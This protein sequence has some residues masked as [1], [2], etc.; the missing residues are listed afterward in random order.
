MRTKLAERGP[1]GHDAHASANHRGKDRRGSNLVVVSNRLPIRFDEASSSWVTAAGGLVSAM[2]PVLARHDGTWVGWNP[3][4]RPMAPMRSMR[5]RGVALPVDIASRYYA[6]YANSVLWPTLHGM[7]DRV[8]CR[9]SWWESY[10]SA[11]EAFADAV[12]RTARQG[13]TVWVHD[14]HL[15]LVPSLLAQRRPDLVIGL[16]LHTP[17]ADTDAIE[18]LEHCDELLAGMAGAQLIGTQR[19]CDATRLRS[20]L[21]SYGRRHR[22]RVMSAVHAHPISVDVDSIV[23]V[24]NDPAV[25]EHA[26][27]VRAQVGAGRRIVLSVDRLDYTKGILERLAAFEKLLE[28]GV[29]SPD[30]V[31]LVQIAP[32][33]RDELP[34]YRD[35]AAQVRARVALINVR[36]PSHRGPAVGLQCETLPFSD[37]AAFYLAADVAMVT[38]LRDGMN[39]VAKEFVTARAGE[40]AC[41]VL[42]VGAGA[43]DELGSHAVLVDAADPLDLAAG[44]H[45]AL[46]L[47]GPDCIARSTALGRTVAN[48]DVHRWADE[49]LADLGSMSCAARV[50]V[51]A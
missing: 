21:D 3:S 12:A 6:G 37:L 48:H 16:F 25:R 42:G 27:R 34:V 46:H 51:P 2:R 40:P 17:V 43:A 13:A 26:A 11:N 41:L 28:L 29:V 18:A 10:R 35:F 38:P 5:L 49:F 24:V 32:P 45:E 4:R 15:L 30:N 36:Y 7:R 19:A 23:A 39:L 44:L 9:P 14:Y 33:T 31:M 8:E 1:R 47:S 22:V 50:Q 20:F